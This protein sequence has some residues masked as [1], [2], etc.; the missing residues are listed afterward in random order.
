M[1]QFLQSYDIW[2][3]GGDSTVSFADA[4]CPRSADNAPKNGLEEL[5]NGR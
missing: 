1:A 5:D 2:I 4:F 3:G